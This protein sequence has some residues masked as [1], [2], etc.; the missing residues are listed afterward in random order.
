M[1]RHNAGITTSTK[2]CRNSTGYGAS[3]I[4]ECR[5]NWGLLIRNRRALSYA[6][7]KRCVG[8]TI[9][10]EDFCNLRFHARICMVTNT[11]LSRLAGITV[12]VS[13]ADTSGS[14][15]SGRSSAGT[16]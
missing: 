16:D 11:E 4:Y 3:P 7:E 14:I 10:S 5:E 13:W 15:I 12:V 8:E 9:R 1:L 2:D 6:K